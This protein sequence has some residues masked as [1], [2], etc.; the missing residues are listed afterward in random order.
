MNTGY[1]F[2]PVGAKAV[3]TRPELVDDPYGV[4][5]WFVD[6]S[7]PGKRDGTVLNA[8]WLNQFIAERLHLASVSGVQLRGNVANDDFLANA[9]QAMIDETMA[10]QALDGVKISAMLDA[11]VGAS[12]RATPD[13]NLDTVIDVI[14]G[15]LESS[16]W[17]TVTQA[18]V[19]NAIEVAIDGLVTTSA[20]DAAIAAAI[21]DLVDGAGA[22]LDTLNELAAALGD[23]ANFASTVTT[24]LSGKQPLNSNLT[25]IAALATTAYGR[26]LLVLADAAAFTALGN[27]FTATLKGL[28]PAPTVSSG[29]YLK[30]DGTWDTPAGGG[31]SVWTTGA[32]SLIYYSA[33][34]VGVGLA[35]PTVPFHVQSTTASGQLIDAYANGAAF[36]M[37]RA[38]GTPGAPTAIASADVLGSI[39]FAGYANGAFTGGKANIRAVAAEAWTATA[40]GVD[41]TIATT[42]I[43][44]ASAVERVRVK[45]SGKVG[46]GTASPG[47]Q[48]TVAGTIEST[49]GGIKFPDATTQAS[50][51]QENTRLGTEASTGFPILAQTKASAPAGNVLTAIA[52]STGNNDATIY[53]KPLQKYVSG[54]WTTVSG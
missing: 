24:A 17:R 5:T 20:L 6:A 10:D 3:T 37:R 33:G 32:G 29:K 4:Q 54:A 8:A 22:T 50:A 51:A 18:Y 38:N 36:Q 25:A 19:T 16:D 43:G 53:Y 31:G 7:A 47:Q 41:I 1:G 11:T 42:P 39:S 12:W 26:G 2:G 44:S 52:I 13:V 27:T 35:V 45:D 48:L 30:D 9:I 46:I 14:D 28:V 49:S 23:D 34:F 40:N 15:I 21:D